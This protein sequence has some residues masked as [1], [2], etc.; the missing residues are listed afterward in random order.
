MGGP[1]DAQQPSYVGFWVPI[2]VLVL[3]IS[4][5]MDPMMLCLSCRMEEVTGIRRCWSLEL[6]IGDPKC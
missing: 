6:V 5:S 4:I 2:S 1:F 3:N